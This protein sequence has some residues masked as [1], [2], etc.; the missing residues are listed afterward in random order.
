MVGEA[1]RRAG[2]P[3]VVHFHGYDASIHSV[4]ERMAASYRRMFDTAGAI[5]A[6]SRAMTRRL[7][8]LGAPAGKVHWNSY[9]VDV[10]AFRGADPAA[11]GPTFLA[12]GRF[13]AKK[14]PHLTL[15]AFAAVHRAY[16]SARLRMIG[17]GDLE[18]ACKALAGELG[19]AP[20]VEF[21]GPCPPER[22]RSEMRQARCFVQHSVEAPNGDSEGTPVSILEAGASGLPVVSTRHAGIPDVVINGQTGFLVA[23]HDVTAM[24]D[25]MLDLA[26]DPALAARLGRAGQDRVRRDFNMAYRVADLWRIVDRAIAAQA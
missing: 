11:A 2:V 5:V 26:C 23:E 12:V 10:A 21:L 25:R 15:R 4:L 3:L 6:V 22:V 8:D 24:A 18:D 1:C 14:A 16:P 7:I 9:G 17:F 19:V 20:V 13:T